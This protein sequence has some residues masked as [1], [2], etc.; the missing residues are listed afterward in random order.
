MRRLVGIFD[1]DITDRKVCTLLFER[2][3]AYLMQGR[4]DARLRGRRTRQAGQK[5][6]G[7]G[8]LSLCFSASKKWNCFLGER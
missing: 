7:G 5:G 2:R 8:V 1:I 3:G 6:G 4:D